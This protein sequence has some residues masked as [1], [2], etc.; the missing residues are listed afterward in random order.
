VADTGNRRVATIRGALPAITPTP[1]PSATATPTGTST[2]VAPSPTPTGTPFTPTPTITATPGVCTER[3]SN[4][5][6]ERDDAWDFPI[7]AN[8]AGYTAAQAHTGQR[9]ARFGLAPTDCGVGIADC[10]LRTD[11]RQSAIGRINLLGEIAPEDAS[12]SSAY[13]T[14]N[15]PANADPSTS[16]LT[17]TFWYK[18]G[19][20]ATEGDYQRV[21]LLDPNGYT[22]I[23]T[24]MKVLEHSDSWRQAHFDLTPYRGQ[25]VVLYFEVYNDNISAGPRTWMFLDDVSVWTCAEL[26]PTPTP[27]IEGRPA[28]GYLPLVLR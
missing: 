4:G 10:G 20:E 12:F 25:S 21:M 15:L 9:S 24:L 11:D 7:T 8:R 16:T 1:T 18:P 26:T 17:L 13:Q 5:G 28:A 23:A 6:F 14:I 22:Y 27:T 2:G 19:T 3:V